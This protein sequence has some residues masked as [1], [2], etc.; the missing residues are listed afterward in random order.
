MLRLLAMWRKKTRLVLFGILIL[1]IILVFLYFLRIQDFRLNRTI[2]T[3]ALKLVQMEKLSQTTAVIYRIEFFDDGYRIDHFSQEEQVWNPFIEGKYCKGVACHTTGWFFYF[4]RGYFREYSQ[5][6]T[7][8]KTPRFLIV[9]FFI[10]GTQKTR[11]LI[12]YRDED[13]RVLG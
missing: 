1:I 8:A 6:G 9:E 12:F 11:K 4:V 13:W 5:E 2:R 3:I 7:T 10:S